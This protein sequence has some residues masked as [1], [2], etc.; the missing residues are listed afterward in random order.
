MPHTFPPDAVTARHN[1]PAALSS[2]VG[3][4]E[5]L[6][7][8]RS[9]LAETRL[10]SVVGPGGAGKTRLAREVAAAEVGS[11][12]FE[13]V[14]W[15]ELAPLRES[16]DVVV[17]L[18]AVLGVGAAPG[19]ALVDAVRTALDQHP[20]LLVLDNCEHL[21]DEVARLVGVLLR[22]V[23]SLRVLATSREPLAVDGEV[24]W[25]IPALALPAATSGT[26][27]ATTVVGRSTAE[28]IAHFDA[29]RL[30]VERVRAVT[31]H[32]TLSDANA[33]AVATLCQRLDGMPLSLELAA[34]VVPVL[35]VDELVTRFEDVLTLLSRGKRTADP[36]HRTLRAVLDWSYDLLTPNE[37]RLLRRLS[38]FRSAFQLDAVEAVCAE[39]TGPRERAETVLALGRLVEQSLVEVRDD[40]RQSRYRL[41]ETVRQY[42]AS[43]L[44]DT[45]DEAVVR[46]RHA[47][48][49]THFAAQREDALFSAAR[50]RTVGE[51]R[52]LVDEIRAALEWAMGPGGDV[53]VAVRLGGVLGW[54]WISGVPWGEARPTVHRILEAHDR[55][56]VPDE[57][58][59]LTE[60]LDLA[61]LSYAIIGLA[62]FAGDTDTML[63]HTARERR[64]RATFDVG[65]LSPADRLTA[66]RQAALSEQLRGIALAMRG[67]T[68]EG[69]PCMD[70]SIA[71][72]TQAGDA[73]LEPV[74]RI[75]RALVHYFTGDLTNALHDYAQAI[76]E[77]RQLGEHWF[78]S[79][80][81]EGMANVQVALGDS[82]SA[83]PFA[84]EAATVL[85]DERDEWFISRACD[86][87]AWVIANAR[88][89]PLV[90]DDA[91]RLAARLM[92]AAE[93]LRRSC[94]A[95]IIGPD[96][97]RDVQMR[98]MLRER[99]GV[100]AFDAAIA[101][102]MHLSLDD[103]LQLMAET[104]VGEDASRA[105]TQPHPVVSVPVDPARPRV[106]VRLLGKL[107]IVHDGVAVPDGQLPSGKVREL[108]AYLVLNDSVTKED[109]GLALWPDASAAQLRNVFH[110]TM[111]HL[112]RHLGDQSWISFE[113]GRYRLLR[114]PLASAHLEIDV[115]LLEAAANDI[116]RLV[117]RQS[118][119]DA[120]Q[121]EAWQA[122]LVTCDGDLLAGLANDEWLVSAQD[123]LR[124]MWAD[125]VDGLVAL[126]RR[127]GRHEQVLALCEMLVRREPYRESAHRAYME[128]LGA[129]G[130][131]ARALV[132]YESLVAML[133]R[134]LDAK[135]SAETR[136][137]VE[138][139][140]G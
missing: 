53:A 134:E 46:E 139:L 102:G 57:A 31:P 59:P 18:A 51:L 111:H 130:E 7:V 14:W 35:G 129:R 114:D 72:A 6:R 80:A 88:S 1:L 74:M 30:F 68:A 60:R 75:R 135:P 117:R 116:R 17:T 73:W 52:L 3:R 77:L 106:T 82:A 58:L 115:D 22:D 25:S 103:V 92:G 9:R 38:V 121:L 67:D 133:A 42:G 28:A 94:G 40:G 62:Y 112:R 71:L 32:F 107:A 123:R 69:L 48:Y 95:G 86:T 124:T 85:V 16:A 76:P 105:V 44:R 126:A 137:V 24:A 27:A 120:S 29:V 4:E 79:L 113:R 104:V 54:F 23:P 98:D 100:S 89:G 78:L 108:L 136:R 99:T 49:I 65:A 47:R 13:S 61:R 131:T 19:L 55:R 12:Q 125:A 90:S 11:R 81:L 132:H 91:S 33:A 138:A 50:G 21:V 140:R 128:A 66:L 64:V 26:V 83:L 84:R 45:P 43:L 5:E 2:F 118:D 122:L 56:G 109:I 15:I 97:Q 87:S 10:L 119:G 37:Q 70:R 20:T 39:G 96:V 34:A 63:E 93:A 8:I 127:A 101:D 36:R 41:L 110:V